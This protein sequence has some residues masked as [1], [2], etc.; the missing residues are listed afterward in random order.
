MPYTEKDIMVG[1]ARMPMGAVVSLTVLWLHAGVVVASP[2]E[3]EGK[4]EPVPAA[5]AE[6]MRQHSWHEGCPVP[7]SDLAYLRLSH[8]GPDGAV[9]EG[10]LVVHKSFAAEVLQIFKALFDQR[11]P[12]TKMRLVDEYEGD[13]DKSIAD[14]NTSAFNCREVAGKPGV[15]SRHS[16]GR[17]IDINPLKNPMILGGKVSPPAGSRYVDRRKKMPGLLRKGDPAVREFTRR[18]WTWGGAW[19]DL[20]DYQHFAK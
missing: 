6:R 1:P 16:Y 8:Y 10:E 14:D 15:L 13:D 7:I 2:P 12:I 18:G 11:F 4:S 3:F 20:K 17:A 19:K 9:H 5:V